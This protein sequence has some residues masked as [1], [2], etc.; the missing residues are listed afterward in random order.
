MTEELDFNEYLRK[1]FNNKLTYEEGFKRYAEDFLRQH[2]ANLRMEADSMRKFMQSH[3]AYRNDEH[4]K[5]IIAGLE[6]AAAMLDPD[7]NKPEPYL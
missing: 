2:R 1:V 3:A 6:K 4:Y 5:G 7:V